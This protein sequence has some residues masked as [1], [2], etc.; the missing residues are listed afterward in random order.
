MRETVSAIRKLVRN[1]L[2]GVATSCLVI[3]LIVY[4]T[5]IQADAASKTIIACEQERDTNKVNVN[6]N[7]GGSTE[8]SILGRIEIPQLKLSVALM[9]NYEAA[10]L[11]KGVGHIPGTAMPGG[12]GTVG[13]AGHRDTY[14]RS[15]RGIKVGMG[16]ELS[17]ATGTYHY[18]VD[19]TEIVKPSQIEVLDVRQRPELTLITCYPFNFIGEAPLR[20]IIHAHL[21]SVIPS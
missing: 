10:D 9:D 4:I 12:L 18:S 7:T 6:P 8:G 11:L 17:D 13:I 21:L 2:Y 15:L 20:F 14:F 3:F 5:S 1:C 16:I 19:S